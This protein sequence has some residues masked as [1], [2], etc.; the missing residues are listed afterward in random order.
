MV[1]LLGKLKQFT[2]FSCLP[3]AEK[4]LWFQ[5]IY[6]LAIFRIKL[7]VISPKNVFAEVIGHSA[8]QHP[9]QTSFITSDRIA[10]I[11]NKV[12]ELLPISTCLSKALAS[13]VLF[14]KYRYLAELHIGVLKNDR[15]RLEAHAWLSYGGKIIIGNLP[16]LSRFR[17]L[18]LKTITN[19]LWV[20]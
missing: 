14:K 7:I 2:Q 10:I 4:F 6:Y 11:I 12:S 5:V 3:F 15:Q 19:Q 16:D 8:S 17:E 1:W 13:Y 18:P 20:E 9:I